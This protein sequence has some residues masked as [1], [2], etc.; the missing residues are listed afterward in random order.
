MA[1]VAA[2]LPSLPA[3]SLGALSLGPVGKASSDTAR[4][5]GDAG[6]AGARPGAEGGPGARGAVQD[7]CGGLSGCGLEWVGSLETARE[8][9]EVRLVNNVRDAIT[10]YAKRHF[11]L[12]RAFH[13]T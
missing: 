10:A 2:P 4:H 13:L 3:G 6:E 5:P 11:H 7:D 1:R 8:R 12:K 9:L